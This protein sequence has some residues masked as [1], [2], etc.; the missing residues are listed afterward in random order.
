MRKLSLFGGFLLLASSAFAGVATCPDNTYVVFPIPGVTGG[1][2][3]SCGNAS[4]DGTSVFAATP[5]NGS[6]GVDVLAS[7]LKYDLDGLFS[8][9]AFSA[10][11]G[12]AALLEGFSLA[13]P[14]TLSFNWSGAFEP[15]ATGALFYILNGEVTVL[16]A[17][18]SAILIPCDEICSTDVPSNQV[19]LNLPAGSHTLGF[20]AITIDSKLIPSIALDPSITVNNFA[21]AASD[22]PE[23]ATLALTA[24]ALV[25][26]AAW[27]R[28]RRA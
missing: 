27:R 8:D 5:G 22:V 20:G 23:P 9:E 13:A 18:Y 3:S 26:L 12:S 25:G 1:A 21:V 7:F 11:E 24:G 19:T 4:V 6:V 16:D 14:S 15:G 10:G 2:A 17:R 28:R